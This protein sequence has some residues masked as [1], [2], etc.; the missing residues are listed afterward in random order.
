M[1]DSFFSVTSAQLDADVPERPWIWEGYL[2]RGQITLFTSLWK[3]G[4]T[5]LL[6]H[7]LAQRH[8]AGTLAGK[9]VTPGVSL[10]VSEEALA[11]WQARH[12]RLKFGP[13]DRFFLR[14]FAGLPTLTEWQEF[15]EHLAEQ[16]RSGGGDLVV[17]DP[18]VCCLP[19]G[20]ENNASLMMDTLAP[21]AK[22]AQ[23]GVAVLLLHH[24]RKAPAA[25][26]MAARGCGALPAF[27]DFIIE[28]RHV[29]GKQQDDR[30]RRL[31]A[32]S[33]DAATP[34]AQL[35]ELSADG[36]A[37][38][39]VNEPPPPDDFS[40]NWPILQMIF[41]D[42]D[43]EL[44]RA[45]IPTA[46]PADFSCPKP[47]TLRKWLDEA[48]DRGLIQREGSGRRSEPFRYFL[49][50]KMAKWQADPIYQLNQKCREAQKIM[51]SNFGYPVH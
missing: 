16:A 38:A 26:G 20:A 4:K 9:T 5:T 41:E 13:H 32:F 2:A 6:S 27:V 8:A 23:A 37:Y 11:A 33:R 30:R 34:R 10:I 18:L 17:I 12:S 19:C 24:P 46:W 21:L 47:T 22:L 31:I 3:F 29:D 25:E 39:L 1:N 44:T 28:M 48:F 42:A 51:L 45:E 43:R 7:L 35:L 40:E 14:P 36:L 50:E 15:V 49:P